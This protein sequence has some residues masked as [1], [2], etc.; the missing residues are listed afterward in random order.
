VTGASAAPS[1]VLGR[2]AVLVA[3][4]AIALLGVMAGLA[5]LGWAVPFGASSGLDHGPLLVVGVFG[6]VIALERAVAYGSPWGYS[7]PALGVLGAWLTA[8]AHSR[9]GAIASLGSAAA[10]M[11]LN[12]A[13]VRRQSAPFTWLMLL[14]SSVLSVG[15]AGALAG[16]A[17][18]ALV[19]SWMVFFALTIVSER[20]ELSRLAPT[21]RWATRA[22]VGLSL[23]LALLVLVGFAAPAL[24]ARL[25]GPPLALAGAW[26]LRFDLARRTI[27]Q[28]GLPRYAAIGVLLGVLW[29]LGAG[30]SLTLLGL[31]GAGPRYDAVVHAVF[32]GFVLS[33]VF[34][35][36]PIILPAVAR[37]EVPFHPA[38][39]APLALLHGGLLVRLA[40][41]ASG[42]FTLRRA[43]GL[44]NALSLA[45]LVVAVLWSRARRPSR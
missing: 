24:G 38:L 43:G 42:V 26:Q 40:G 19:P 27:R 5:R 9:A 22:L 29:L 3:T 7:A 30:L 21:P 2:R 37:V 15:A 39:Y 41:D 1:G 10:L 13:I 36:A 17:T 23:A 6:T 20:L 44:V 8:F 34:A 35:H 14:G 4:A 32:V 31:P 25:I 11:A 33:M 28:P 16:R 18:V 45:A 12:V